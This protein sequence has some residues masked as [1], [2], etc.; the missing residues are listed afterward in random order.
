MKTRVA[1]DRRKGLLNRIMKYKLKVPLQL[2]TEA[3]YRRDAQKV[4]VTREFYRE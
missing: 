4:M 2:W 3:N 1:A